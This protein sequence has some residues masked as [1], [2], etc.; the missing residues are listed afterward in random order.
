M[1]YTTAE[2]VR[3]L[4]HFS[5]PGIVAYFSFLGYFLPFP[6]E[7]VFIV[8]GYLAGLGKFNFVLLFIS[9]ISGVL[10]IDN[11]FYWL[12]YKESEHIFHFKKKINAEVFKKY[13]KLMS[14]NIGKTMFLLRLFVGFRFLG[15][16]IAGSLKIKWYKFFLYDVFIS[17]GYAGVFMYAGFFFRHRLPLVISYAEKFHSLLVSAVGILVAFILIKIILDRGQT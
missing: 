1:I 4:S 9:A 6:D 14:G 12:S 11:I 8:F 13:E 5:Y 16:V 7:G 10:I 17:A 2:L 15:P 3:Y